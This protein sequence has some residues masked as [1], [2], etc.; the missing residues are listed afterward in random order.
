M[1]QRMD[2][3]IPCQLLEERI[4]PF[5]PKAGKG[6]RP[7]PLSVMLRILCVQLS[8]DLSDPGGEEA[9]GVGEGESGTPFPEDEASV[10]L[11]QSTLPRTGQEHGAAGAAAGNGQPDDSGEIS[12]GI[13][14]AV[15]GKTAIRAVSGLQR[16]WRGR[17]QRPLTLTKTAGRRGISANPAS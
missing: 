7:Y 17:N 9:E 1:G 6:R 15:A 2:G 16:T 11:R 12:G 5:Y 14:G 13:T 3:L 8:Y 4:R 10:W